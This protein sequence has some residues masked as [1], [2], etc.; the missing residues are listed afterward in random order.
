MRDQEQIKSVAKCAVILD[1]I[2]ESPQ[3]MSL[4]E[5]AARTQFSRP[6]CYR[7]LQT[8]RA[9][10][11]VEQDGKTKKYR[12][13]IKL[14]IL[15]LSALRDLDLVKVATPIMKTLKEEIKEN[16]NLAIIDGLEVI[17]VE[18][19]PSD[20]LMNVTHRVGSRFPVYCSAVGKAMLAFLPKA[21]AK[22]ILD[23]QQFEKLTEKTHLSAE[24][25]RLELA[26]IRQ[27]GFAVADEELERGLVAVAAPVFDYTGMPVAA[28]GVSYSSARYPLQDRRVRFSREVLK[29]AE[30]ISMLMGGRRKSG[31][32]FIQKKLEGTGAV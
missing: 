32:S 9:L 16:V 29:A 5:L 8:M 2:S 12:L 31:Q 4:D 19:I 11:I 26:E 23:G 18:R 3:H 21:K 10:G 20:Y 14:M 7:L 27:L 13:G 6:T 30:Q 24:S 22:E 17:F 1:C 15:G 28:V 25:L